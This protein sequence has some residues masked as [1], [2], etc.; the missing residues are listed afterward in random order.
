MLAYLHIC[1]S[2]K[3]LT[4]HTSLIQ[5]IVDCLMLNLPLYHSGTHT[6]R[7][8][9]RIGTGNWRKTW[10]GRSD[11]ACTDYVGWDWWR[12]TVAV[13]MQRWCSDCWC[14]LLELTTS[15]CGADCCW[16]RLLLAAGDAYCWLAAD[17]C[18]VLA[19]DHCWLWWCGVLLQRGDAWLRA[20]DPLETTPAIVSWFP[21]RPAARE[22]TLAVN[23]IALT[24]WP[25]RCDEA[26]PQSRCE[27]TM[28]DEYRAP[29]RDW[30]QALA[31][32]PDWKA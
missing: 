13:L 25:G 2:N 5:S 19:A 23:E 1:Q 21:L 16:W 11:A 20:D 32:V 14:W 7:C 27:G 30:C 28:A 9:F 17:W 31:G 8:E 29:R 26:W 22:E 6:W 12:D 4:L 18:W 15:G 3:E 10:G 24:T